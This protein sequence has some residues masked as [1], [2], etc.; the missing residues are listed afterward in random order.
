MK[1]EKRKRVKYKKNGERFTPHENFIES[2]N[3]LSEGGIKAKRVKEYMLY[4]VAGGGRIFI[5]VPSAYIF[6]RRRN[7]QYI[8]AISAFRILGFRIRILGFLS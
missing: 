7:M 5:P 1:R 3:I 2:G 6:W 4:S 8:L